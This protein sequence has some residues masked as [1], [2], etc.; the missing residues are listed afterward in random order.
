MYV[1]CMYVCVENVHLCFVYGVCAGGAVEL[2]EQRLVQHHFFSPAG[3]GWVNHHF[4][5][6]GF[7]HLGKGKRIIQMRD[8]IVSEVE[9]R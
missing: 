8:K 7:E 9:I 6:K 5:V 1:V 2:S 3:R 4:E